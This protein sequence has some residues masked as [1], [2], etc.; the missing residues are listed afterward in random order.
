MIKVVNHIECPKEWE[1]TNDW[2]SHRCLLWLCVNKLQPGFIVE[3]GIG[4]G[5]TPLL[6]SS[7][8]K[9]IAMETDKEWYNKFLLIINGIVLHV[10][11]WGSIKPIQSDLLFVDCKPGE[12]RKK[13]IEKSK[14]T[15]KVI[16]AHDTEN[17]AD[18]VYGM[19][20]VLST[21][22]YRLDFRPEGL[23]H[24]TAVSNFVNVAEWC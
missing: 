4:Y 8:D 15:S 1:I 23:P 2:D 6:D 14:D 7:C 3:C 20:D 9:F 11:D 21:F 10:D 19:Q 16:V 17:N 24:T 22:K 18:Y 13:I 5:S 12:D